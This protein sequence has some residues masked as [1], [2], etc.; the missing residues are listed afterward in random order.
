[1]GEN[2]SGLVRLAKSIPNTE[3]LNMSLNG[4]KRRVSIMVAKL[5]QEP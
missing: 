2:W 1:M 3:S 4:N 5:A